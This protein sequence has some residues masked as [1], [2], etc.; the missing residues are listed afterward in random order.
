MRLALPSSLL[1]SMFPC[2][3]N[4]SMPHVSFSLL[5]SSFWP[6]SPT[7]LVF[8]GRQRSG[9]QLTD[10]EWKLPEDVSVSPREMDGGVVRLEMQSVYVCGEISTTRQ[11]QS[12]LIVTVIG[13]GTFMLA[14]P[15]AS[16][17]TACVGYAQKPKRT[18]LLW[19]TSKHDPPALFEG[20]CKLFNP[21]DGLLCGEAIKVSPI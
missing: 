19:V 8:I 10:V 14:M 12:K 6:E 1:E 18:L 3:F 16:R 9:L 17:E 2:L 20:V 4:D 5:A 7:K 15:D 11:Q 13:V 21:E